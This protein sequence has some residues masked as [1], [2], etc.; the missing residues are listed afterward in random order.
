MDRNHLKYAIRI[1]QFAMGNAI[2]CFT[3]DNMAEAADVRA[4][5]L[6]GPRCDGHDPSLEHG[7]PNLFAL[8]E[9]HRIRASFFVEG[10]NGMHHPDAVAE[11]VQR[12]HEL[13]MHGWVHEAWQQLEPGE[14]AALAQRA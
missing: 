8:L 11:I 12:G 7:Y 14:E 2:A 1:P 6:D 10:W 3:F 5:R 4:G 13:G 9:R